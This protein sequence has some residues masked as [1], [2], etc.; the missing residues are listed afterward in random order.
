MW[1]DLDPYFH[2][3]K[4]FLTYWLMSS[5]REE[6]SD[7]VPG[8][9]NQEQSQQSQDNSSEPSTTTNREKTFICPTCLKGFRS[10]QQLN[11]HSLVHSGIRKYECSYCDKAFKQLS[12]LQQH[13]RIHTGWFLS[14]VWLL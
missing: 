13:Q 5:N 3:F 7:S 9:G 4:L 10:K 12:H 8:P 6:M 14:L 2:N 11:Q 1:Q